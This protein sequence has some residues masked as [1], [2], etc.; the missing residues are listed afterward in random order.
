MTI[1]RAIPRSSA[2]LILSAL[3][4]AAAISFNTLYSARGVPADDTYYACLYGG[5]LSQVNTT[6][7]PANCGRGTQIQWNSQGIAGLP[8]A[9]GVDGVSGWEYVESETETLEPGEQASL[10]VECPEDKAPLGG[11]GVTQSGIGGP[12]L[13]GGRIITTSITGGHE[14]WFMTVANDHDFDIT[15]RVSVI[16]AFVTP[17]PE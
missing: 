5:S 14:G 9:D 1:L 2:A 16:C 4:I 13:E 8:G 3:I 10:T 17:D 7:P 6:A 15:V 11:G 12:I